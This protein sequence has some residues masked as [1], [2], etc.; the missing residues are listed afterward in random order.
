VNAGLLY[1]FV[2]GQSSYCVAVSF[3]FVVELQFLIYM[4]NINYS[5]CLL[6]V[7]YYIYACPSVFHA[8]EKDDNAALECVYVTLLS[9]PLWKLTF[10]HTC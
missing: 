1:E 7:S 2:V 10:V 4:C 8:T 6:R 9:I 3:I 5:V